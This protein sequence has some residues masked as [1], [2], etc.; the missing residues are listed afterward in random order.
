MSRVKPTS[1]I[2]QPQSRAKREG[3]KDELRDLLTDEPKGS[4]QLADEVAAG[5]NLISQL[6]Q[7]MVDDGKIDREATRWV[8]FVSDDAQEVVADD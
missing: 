7:E 3:L 2:E 1:E 4:Y 6:L 8:Y 5:P